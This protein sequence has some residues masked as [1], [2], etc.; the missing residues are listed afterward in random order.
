MHHATYQFLFLGPLIH[1]DLLQ[2]IPFALRGLAA[3][4]RTRGLLGYDDYIVRNFAWLLA[5]SDTNCCFARVLF[6]AKVIV[7]A[8]LREKIASFVA[9]CP[10]DVTT[11]TQHIA[12][13]ND[14]PLRQRWL[15]PAQVASKPWTCAN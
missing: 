4:K 11:C 10:L 6:A 13:P 9:R 12:E 15:G 14:Q 2:Q 1:V 5:R 3:T 8:T 7:A